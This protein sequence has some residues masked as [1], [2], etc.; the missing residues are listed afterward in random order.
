MNPMKRAV[1]F[2]QVQ[3]LAFFLRIFPVVTNRAH[4]ELEYIFTATMAAFLRAL[5]AGVIHIRHGAI[6][7]AHFGRLGPSFDL[8]AK[9]MIE[10]L[11]EEGMYK[12]NG[13]LVAE[14]ITESLQNV[15]DSSV[16]CGVKYS[17]QHF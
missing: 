6:L 12:D 9:L 1:C 3:F 11:R 16:S 10:I 8:S 4:L 13:G 14:I 5:R 17:D 2:P 15:S 7:L